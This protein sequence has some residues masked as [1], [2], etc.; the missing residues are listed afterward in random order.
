MHPHGVLKPQRLPQLDRGSWHVSMPL[1]SHSRPTSEED[2]RQLVVD[3]LHGLASLH[4]LGIVH[5]DVRPP[6]ILQVI[7]NLFLSHFEMQL[8]ALLQ[9]PKCAAKSASE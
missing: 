8:I 7:P 4:D 5:R 6:N 3:V 1:A 9:S 2:L